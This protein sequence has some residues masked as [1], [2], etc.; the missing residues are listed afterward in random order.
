MSYYY[1][2]ITWAEKLALRS[3]DL[4][5]TDRTDLHIHV[6]QCVACAVV[7]AEYLFLD[8]QLR[9]LPSPVIKPLS[10]LPLRNVHG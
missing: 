10:R 3:E 1:P 9:V 5:P 7:Q 4:S 8:A 2:C 6:Q